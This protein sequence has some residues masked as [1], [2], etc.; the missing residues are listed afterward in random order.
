VK[1]AALSAL[2]SNKKTCT[3]LHT[4]HFHLLPRIHLENGCFSVCQEQY[5]LYQNTQLLKNQSGKLYF[6]CFVTSELNTVIAG[7]AVHTIAATP[8]LDVQKPHSQKLF[9]NIFPL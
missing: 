6:P 3:D 8:I 9:F 2:H 5:I 1:P 4:V 7:S